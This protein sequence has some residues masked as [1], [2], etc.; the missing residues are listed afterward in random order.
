MRDMRWQDIPAVVALEQHV[1]PQT[2]WTVA[3]WWAELAER[4]RRAY[5]V[6][7][8]REIDQELSPQIAG[9]AGV[10]IGGDEAD[11]MTITVDDAHRGTGIGA[12]LLGGLH[13]RAARA[14]AGGILLEVRAD[15]EPAQRLYA[16]SGYAV[17]NR[18]RAYYQPEGVDAIVMRADLSVA[19]GGPLATG[20]LSGSA[21]DEGTG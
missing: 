21:E 11:V 2:A 5:L 12:K 9:Y 15:N 8:G 19:S 16:R 14:G 18:R 13:D 10:D 4:P 1:Y 6:C 3:T 20:T 17:I 7:T